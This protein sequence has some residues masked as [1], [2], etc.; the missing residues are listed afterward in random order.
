[1]GEVP[2]TVAV[3]G[4][5]RWWLRAEGLVALVACVALYARLGNGWLLFAVLLLAPDLAMLGYLRGPAVGA[6]VYNVVHSYVLPA[7]LFAA[8][9]LGDSALAV[10]LSLI[11]A[12]HIGMDRALGFGLKDRAGFGF[13]HLGLSGRAARRAAGPAG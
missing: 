7:L 13:T 12:A 1:M 5:V 9:W 2:S 6:A 3:A 11:W 8:G 4:P 10:A